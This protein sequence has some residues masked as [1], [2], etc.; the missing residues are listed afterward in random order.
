MSDNY[1]KLSDEPLGKGAFGVVYLVEK[2]S[3]KEKY[4]K[5]LYSKLPKLLFKI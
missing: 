4:L 2:K 3:T 1:E 5:I